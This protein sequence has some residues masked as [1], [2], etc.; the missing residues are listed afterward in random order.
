MK[1]LGWIVSIILLILLITSQ[2]S[3]RKYKLACKDYEQAIIKYEQAIAIYK[4]KIR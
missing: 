1:Y 4:S 2:I 3:I